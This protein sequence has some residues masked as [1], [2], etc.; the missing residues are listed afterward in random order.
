V[1]KFNSAN[2]W[3]K[4]GISVCPVKYGM[5]WSGYNAGVKIGVISDDGTIIVSHS[6]AEL[7]QGINTKVAQAVAY[8]LGVEIS[9]IR[10]THATTNYVSNG[11]VTGGSGYNTNGKLLY[12]YILSI[13]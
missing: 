7:G 10:V 2:L 9:I 11:G 8:A 3:R 6:G 4:K 1:T 5:G 13:Q 12:C